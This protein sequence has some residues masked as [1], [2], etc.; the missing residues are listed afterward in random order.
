MELEVNEESQNI[1]SWLKINKLSLHASKSQYMVLS[2]YHNQIDIVVIRFEGQPIRRAT[3][4]K[5]LN[6]II[7]ENLPGVTIR[8][9]TKKN[10]TTRNV[11]YSRQKARVIFPS[12]SILSVCLSGTKF[13]GNKKHSGTF[14]A[15]LFHIVQIRC[16]GG[17][18]SWS[19][20]CIEWN[21]TIRYFTR[22]QWTSI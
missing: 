10:Q 9:S 6:V 15:R 21:C 7:D 22:H 5:F 16:G 11:Y 13:F 17:M 1:A 18:C 14:C 2:S 8:S 3:Q 19:A 4:T 20:S 12:T